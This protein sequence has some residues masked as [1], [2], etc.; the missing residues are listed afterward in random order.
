MAVNLYKNVARHTFLQAV[1]VL[2]VH[3]Q[4]QTFLVQ[5]ADEV[6]DVIGSMSAR[7]QLFGQREER[8]RIVGEVVDIEDGFR[9]WNVVLFQVGIQA[10]AWGSDGNKDHM[11]E[12]AWDKLLL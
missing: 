1:D 6:M 8:T 10:C 9:V 4:Q 3:A 2:G 12:W 7:V 11:E 5:H